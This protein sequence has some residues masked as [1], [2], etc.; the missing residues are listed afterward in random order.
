MKFLRL[1]TKKK[2]ET[3]KEARQEAK[4][5]ASKKLALLYLLPALQHPMLLKRDLSGAQG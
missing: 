5:T 3:Q 2:E 4:T 1:N